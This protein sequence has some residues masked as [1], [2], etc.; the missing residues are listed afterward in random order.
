[1]MRSITILSLIAL[2]AGLFALAI[3]S[4]T[5]APAELWQ[6]VQGEGSTLHRTLV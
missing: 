1:M 3:G 4:V 6:V 2:L 5:I